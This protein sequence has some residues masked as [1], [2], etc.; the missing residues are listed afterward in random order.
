MKLSKRLSTVKQYIPHSSVVADIGC[1]RGELSMAL[2]REGIADKVILIDI[3]P[4]SLHRAEQFF[5]DTE[6]YAKA[7]FRVGDG[8]RVLAPYEAEYTVFAGMGGLTICDILQKGA[9]VISTLKGMVLQAQGNSDK[10]RKLL[11]ETGFRL[12]AE[13]MVKE[14]GKYYTVLFA[15]PGTMALDETELFAGPFLLK[16]RDSVLKA[17]FNEE[18]EKSRR[19]LAELVKNGQ[20]EPRQAEL[21]RYLSLIEAAEKRMEESDE[22]I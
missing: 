2:L 13:S 17:Y 19:I 5:E 8:V 7:V 11:A 6:E 21:R 20:G 3:S 15:V 9:D 18:K 22:I 16:S 4:Q 1:D 14:D 12:E 10:V